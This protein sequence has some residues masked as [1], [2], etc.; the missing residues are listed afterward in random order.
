MSERKHLAIGQEVA[1]VDRGTA[2]EAIGLGIIVAPVEAE[3]WRAA[4][5]RGQAQRTTQRRHEHEGIRERV[6]LL[7]DEEEIERRGVARLLRSLLHQPFG[8]PGARRVSLR[9]RE[10]GVGAEIAPAIYHIDGRRIGVAE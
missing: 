10:T 1:G 4:S 6:L 3:Y 5:G 2:V 7:V 9:R 8:V